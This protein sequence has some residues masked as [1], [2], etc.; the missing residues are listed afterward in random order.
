MKNGTSLTTTKDKLGNVIQRTRGDK[1]IDFEY[2]NENRVVKS[3]DSV[4]GEVEYT[5]DEEGNLTSVSSCDVA[6]SYTYD[7]DNKCTIRTVTVGEETKSFA[8]TYKDI[9]AKPLASISVDG[10]TVN[11][12]LDVNGRN[13][14]KT[15]SVS[16][17]KIAEE[18]IAY[19][20]FGDR[21]TLLP[22]TVRYGNNVNGRYVVRDSVKY[23]Y[24]TMGNITEVFENGLSVAKYEYDALGRLKREDN[25]HFAKTTLFSYDD[26]GN[27]LAKYEYVFTNIKTDELN[28]VEPERTVL[29]GYDEDSDRLLTIDDSSTE[30]VDIFEYDEIGNPTTYRGKS[31]TWS[32]GREMTGFDG[33][34][35]AY[36]ARG[37]RVSKNDIVFTYDSNGK[38]IGQY[39]KEDGRRVDNLDFIYDHTGLLAVEYDGVRY[40][41]RKNAQ[42]DIIAILDNDGNIVVKYMYDAWGVCTTV[43]IDEN[44]TDI[45]NLNPFRYRS[46]YFDTE[47]NLYFLK[48]RYY[49]PEICRFIT[50]DDISYLAPDTI[51]GLNLYAYC[52]NNPIL[53]YDPIGCNPIVYF[54]I[55]LAVV[56]VVGAIW[57]GISAN[58]RAKEENAEGG[59]VDESKSTIKGVITG[60]A[61]GLAIGGAVL[62]L[63]SVFAGAYTAITG[64]AVTI[65][66]VAVKQIFA[67]GALAINSV[68]FIIA[69]LFGVEMDGVE[70]PESGA[71][72]SQ[73]PLQE[74]NHPAS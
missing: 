28:T 67:L 47:T 24:D 58:K 11:P 66:D 60:F 17:S 27:I 38:L 12:E 50:I 65:F 39:R 33:N 72:G 42:N 57:G 29:Y 6:E 31:V 15:V 52:K 70:M 43:V 54:M 35:F 16:G 1:T 55:G 10:I 74:D 13:I 71:S 51:N 53:Y 44:A 37:R 7:E 23:R 18:Q 8:F 73:P 2:D 21:A 56:A 26:N 4:S 64:V 22:S 20:K 62:T 9:K 30:T 68:A 14:G 3:E 63:V 45:A 5:Y 59:E 32:C 41:Y 25:K 61:A 19:L 49:D 34:T 46:Y 69:P 36:D 40:F 48:T